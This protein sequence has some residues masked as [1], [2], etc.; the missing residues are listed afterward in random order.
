MKIL[1]EGQ[2]TAISNTY[3]IRSAS[4]FDT[5]VRSNNK[6]PLSKTIFI[7]HWHADKHSIAKA[8]PILKSLGIDIWV[9]WNDESMPPHTNILTAQILK[10]Q[11]R[12]NKFFILLATNTAIK[13]Q[14][15]NWELG[16]GDILKTVN[17]KIALLPLA[18]TNGEWLG[19][20]YLR[21]YPC[22][23]AANNTTYSNDFHLVYPDGLTMT[24]KQWIY[25]I[26]HFTKP[27]G[28]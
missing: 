27:L 7:S 22:T 23:K 10:G 6:S 24:L 11:I 5:P 3:P 12:E 20:E 18:N 16:I 19:N 14:W 8:I 9:D 25:K 2:F 28:L 15:C 1:S 26:G 17:D 13:S 21:L 4:G